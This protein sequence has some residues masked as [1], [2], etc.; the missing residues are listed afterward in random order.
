MKFKHFKLVSEH[1]GNNFGKTIDTFPRVQ[2]LL[3][4]V[5]RF[6]VAVLVLVDENVDEITDGEHA[7]VALAFAA[8]QRCRF[9]ACGYS[10]EEIERSVVGKFAKFSNGD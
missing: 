8:P 1:F 6:Q 7:N 2:F 10:T 5:G 9:D 3:L 4:E